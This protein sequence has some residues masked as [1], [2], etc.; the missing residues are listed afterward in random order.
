MVTSH[1]EDN[2]PRATD[3]KESTGV[4]CLGVV[5]SLGAGSLGGLILIAV[6]FWKTWTSAH[7]PRSYQGGDEG[8][9]FGVVMTLLVLVMVATASYSFVAGIIGSELFMVWYC[10][11]S[12]K[13]PETSSQTMRR[14][15]LLRSLLYGLI[16]GL[17]Y[18]LLM[19]WLIKS[20]SLG[21]LGSIESLTCFSEVLMLSL[22]FS[23]SGAFLFLWRTNQNSKLK[24]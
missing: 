13:D 6:P 17:I 21:E 14:D 11:Y 19:A 3:L 9:V 7:D 24:S 23:V 12:T 2:S 16:V 5:F 22:V 8:L 1:N 20:E 18:D 15:L 10:K 4:G